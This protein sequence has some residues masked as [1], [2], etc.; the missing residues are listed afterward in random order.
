[1]LRDDW[2]HGEVGATRA[3]SVDDNAPVRADRR[4]GLQRGVESVLR[5]DGGHRG[6]TPL[7]RIGEPDEIAGAAI[8]LASR[9]VRS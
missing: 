1:M 7:R 2:R 8:F 4:P 9:L 5:A 6:R 3:R